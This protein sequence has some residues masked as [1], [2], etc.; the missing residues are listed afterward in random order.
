MTQDEFEDEDFDPDNITEE[1]A[2]LFGL[3]VSARLFTLNNEAN[4][5]LLGILL[6]ETDDSFLVGIPSRLVKSGEEHFIQPFAPVPYFRLLKNSVMSVMYPFGIFTEKFNEYVKTEGVELY[7]PL[8]DIMTLDA[9]EEQVEE[10]PEPPQEQNEVQV[11]GMS[12][13]ELKEYLAKR[14]KEGGIPNGY[15]N[16]H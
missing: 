11:F 12:D 1:D 13:D 9:E 4:T 16:K 8:A 6:E 15:D 2:L 10:T 7:P 5:T 3:G 14:L